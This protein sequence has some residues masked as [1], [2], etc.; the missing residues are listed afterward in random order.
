MQRLLRHV[1]FVPTTDI[2]H[3]RS[4]PEYVGLAS[5]ALI[6]LQQPIVHFERDTSLANKDNALSFEAQFTVGAGKRQANDLSR[7]QSGSKSGPVVSAD[8]LALPPA[9]PETSVASNGVKE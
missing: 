8:H 1:R 9:A 6:R 3:F 4:K 7:P 2:R 5:V